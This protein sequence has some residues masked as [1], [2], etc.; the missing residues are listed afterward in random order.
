[1][2]EGSKYL[3]QDISKTSNHNVSFDPKEKS[4]YEALFQKRDYSWLC[5]ILLLTSKYSC[6]ELKLSYPSQEQLQML[7]CN[8]RKQFLVLVHTDG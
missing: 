8:H 4:V 6:G 5:I 7:K 1:M 3:V 2:V